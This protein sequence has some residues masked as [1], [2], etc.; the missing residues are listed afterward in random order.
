MRGGP[1]SQS[2]CCPAPPDTFAAGLVYGCLFQRTRNIAAPWLAHV[3]ASIAFIAAG[4]MEF[5]Q[6]AF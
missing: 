6:P 5:T 4:V 2:S 3:I 1:I